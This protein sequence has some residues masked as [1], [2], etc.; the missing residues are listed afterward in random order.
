MAVLE[1]M[2][3]EAI[4]SQYKGKLDFYQWN[5]IPVCRRWPRPPTGQ[6]SAAVQAQY[7]V[8]TYASRLWSFLPPDIQ[9]AY[10]ASAAGTDYVGRDV[11]TKGYISGYLAI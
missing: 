10:R 3:S 6:R 7:P 2:P 9:A 5:G 1:R 4:I 8:W 11:A